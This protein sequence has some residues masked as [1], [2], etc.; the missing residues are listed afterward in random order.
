MAIDG[1]IWHGCFSGGWTKAILCP[2]SFAHPAKVSKRLADRIYEH[3]MERGWL[4]R[5]AIVVDPFGGIGGFALWPALHGVQWVGCE[6]EA[7]FV[8]LANQNFAMWRRKWGHDP[9]WVEPRMVLGDSRAL[10]SLLTSPGQLGSMPEGAPPLVISSPPYI[11]SVTG[12]HRETET[13]AESRA[14]RRTAGGSLGQSAR[15]GGYGVSDGQLGGMAEGQPPAVVVGSPPYEKQQTGG[16]LAKPNARYKDETRIGTNCGYQNAADS[17]VNLGNQQGDT[18]WA[19]S[20]AI[21]EQFHA[22][23]PPSGHA[24]WVLKA[25]VRKGKL[26][27]F[28]A[29]WE[30]L[31]HEVGFRTCCRHRA[32]LVQENEP[33]H[34]LLGDGP[35]SRR[36]EKKSFFRR[37]AEKKGSPAIDWEDVL[38]LERRG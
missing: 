7:R 27:D 23:L 1:E 12:D 28:P 6:L 5:G 15:H 18:F 4:R 30:A 24:I 17:K 22:L 37:L 38:C 11:E 9:D 25:F 35:K 3:A 2:E 21:L 14:K 34:S 26:V 33:Q 13:A 31:C 29:Q 20:R 8:E 32:M 10:C 19:A 16:G 36:T